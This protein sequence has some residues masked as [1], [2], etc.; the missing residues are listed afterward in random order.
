MCS[1]GILKSCDFHSPKPISSWNKD[2]E[3]LKNML[4]S[5][6]M[7]N[8]MSI[9]VCS[10]LLKFF[11]NEIFPKIQ[12]TFV[13]VTGDSDLCVPREM[14]TQNETFKLLNSPYLLKW[15]AQNTRIQDN[16]KIIQ[17][18][19]GLDYHTISSNP[20][21]PWKL[22]KENPLPRFQELT[23]VSIKEKSIPFYE[24]IPKIYITYITYTTTNDRFGQRQNSL[25]VIPKELMIK[26]LNF[27]SR[28]EL[29]QEM[30]NYTFILSPAG[31][32][33][34]CHR[35]WEALCLGC[36]P[37]VCIPEF[38]KMF[39]DLPV[40]VVDNW[41]QITEELLQQ[42]VELFKTKQFNYEKL[43]LSY[44]KNMMQIT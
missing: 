10:D 29:W 24:R 25:N 11:V 17:L 30:I 38:R 43:K 5:N 3:Y 36:I 44:W 4:T 23:L 37:I 32:G 6:N 22:P 39:A 18:P 21:H 20:Q 2:T 19:I 27:T 8:G 42:T 26:K 34:D 12:T 33:L 28:T 7:K 15:F 9:Y 40:L 1:R 41:E 35:T 16:D 13:L 14:L 31:V